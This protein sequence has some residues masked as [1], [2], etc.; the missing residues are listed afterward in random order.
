MKS[1]LND[2]SIVKRLL[3]ADLLAYKPCNAE[4]T[5]EYQK[6]KKDGEPLPKGVIW[7][8]NDGV[9][10]K[11]DPEEFSLENEKHLV[12]VAQTLY[13]KSINGWLTFL[14]VLTIIGLV[15]GLITILAVF[16]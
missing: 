2:T 7:S 4:E 15:G 5:A 3:K 8:V 6:L 14:G 10:I 11:I 12:S 13:L 9:F 16:A 1:L